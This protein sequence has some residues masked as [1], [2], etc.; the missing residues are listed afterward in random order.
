LR[1]WNPTSHSQPVWLQKGELKGFI[2]KIAF[3]ADDLTL[4]TNGGQTIS[5]LEITLWDVSSGKKQIIDEDGSAAMSPDGKIVAVKTRD[6]KVSVLDVASRKELAVYE[7]PSI[8]SGYDS[9]VALSANGELVALKVEGT[10]H[11]WDFKLGKLVASLG[12][13]EI[14]TA[15]FSPDGKT[16]AS[17]SSDG[18]AELWDLTSKTKLALLYGHSASVRSVAF[19]PDGKTLATA[20]EDQTIKLWD[21]TPRTDSA[22]TEAF[23]PMAG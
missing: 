18:T 17:G 2:D 1:L 22:K 20:S 14:V 16:L 11:L 12:Q 19:S 6:N 7:T 21:A 5:Q 4:V 3:S 23:L 13:S 10:L 9:F 15:L 8:S